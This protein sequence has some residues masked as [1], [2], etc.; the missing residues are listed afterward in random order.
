MSAFSTAFS[1]YSKDFG[2][3]FAVAGLALFLINILLHNQPSSQSIQLFIRHGMYTS[4]SISHIAFGIAGS[5]NTWKVKKHYIDTW[6]RPNTTRGFLWL[7]RAPGGDL[8][9]W[10]PSSPPFRISEDIVRFKEYNKHG[11]PHAIRMVHV[12]L[13]T[14]REVNN[15]VRWYVMADDDTVLF[16]DNLVE[17]L[18]QYDHKKYYYIG[19]NSECT[20]SNWDYSFDMAFGGAGYA[21]SFP[22]AKAVAEHLDLCLMRYPTLYGSDHILQACIADLGVTLTHERGFHQVRLRFLLDLPELAICYSYKVFF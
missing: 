1:K 18:S 13:E 6:W 11:M 16:V 9:P 21:L 12:I 3:T 2:K 17:L 7:D 20:A 19:G 15:G 8:L 5:V 14:F 4:T 10:P 22:L